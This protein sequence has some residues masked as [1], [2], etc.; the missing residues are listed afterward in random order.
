[1]Y[2]LDAERARCIVP[3]I[4][5]MFSQWGKIRRS[6]KKKKGVTFLIVA[7][8]LLEVAFP[9]VVFIQTDILARTDKAKKELTGSSQL[10]V[11]RADSQR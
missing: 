4:Q 3:G 6:K 11:R 8:L 5:I 9:R 10:G 7:R 2:S 1:M